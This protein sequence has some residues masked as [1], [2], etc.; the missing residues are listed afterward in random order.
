MIA[1]RE[2]A[3]SN[4]RDEERGDASSPSVLDR[5]EAWNTT[6]RTHLVEITSAETPAASPTGN[7]PP[8]N[9]ALVAR[10]HECQEI[11]T[12]LQAMH[13]M[14]VS[15][16][17]DSRIGATVNKFTKR[18]YPPLACPLVSQASGLIDQWKVFATDATTQTASSTISASVPALSNVRPESTAS[19]KGRPVNYSIPLK[20]RT[21]QVELVKHLS[22]MQSSMQ[23][24]NSGN[25]TSARRDYE[26][27]MECHT[28][29]DRLIRIQPLTSALLKDSKLAK[30]VAKFAQLKITHQ[31]HAYF[32]SV[33]TRCQAIMAHWTARF[34]GVQGLPLQALTAF[35][36]RVGQLQ[37]E[38]RA[39]PDMI[40]YK[41]LRRE[42]RFS[43][44]NPKIN[45][46]LPDIPVGVRLK[47]RGECAIVGIHTNILSGID[48]VR[49]QSCFAVCMS[50]KYDDDEEESEGTIY[51][52]GMG[53]QDKRRRQ[54]AD[55]TETPANA[56]LIQSS[57]TGD[58][59]RVLRRLGQGGIDYQY[60]GLYECVD[61]LYEASA[62]GQGPKVYTFILKPIPEK[63]SWWI[64]KHIRRPPPERLHPPSTAAQ[65]GDR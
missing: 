48:A 29:L 12:Q 38:G 19:S 37:Q 7:G 43:A 2:V 44:L 53:G 26:V 22:V 46:A 62:D 34:I 50:G 51:Y 30:T 54:I 33:K 5:L 16:L 15:L 3:N 21:L 39:K 25:T 57:L 32:S 28:L 52:T 49:D 11:L 1:M 36:E 31:Q 9:A 59:I 41:E 47:G 63:S 23:K 14:S 13:N 64:Q 60:E 4:R 65:R 55:Q 8:Q 40:A 35:R 27:V 17:K 58:H 24:E 42:R 61:Y 6:L 56:A 18:R 10:H 45:G 20:A